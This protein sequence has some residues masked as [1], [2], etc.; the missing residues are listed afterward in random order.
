MPP[1]LS[2]ARGSVSAL[3]QVIPSGVPRRMIE[4]LLS[5]LAHCRLAGGYIRAVPGESAVA[6]ILF[7]QPHLTHTHTPSLRWHSQD[8]PVKHASS[9]TPSLHPCTTLTTELLWENTLSYVTQTQ[10]GVSE[11]ME[12]TESYDIC[13]LPAV[14]PE[15][16]WVAPQTIICKLRLE[17]SRISLSLEIIWKIMWPSLDSRTIWH[18]EILLD[19]CL[20]CLADRTQKKGPLQVLAISWF[21]FSFSLVNFWKYENEMKSW[22]VSYTSM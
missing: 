21:F 16:H 18:H 15:L 17:A 5:V 6:G 4:W 14:G 11:S 22:V 2:A 20:H 1:K 7:T 8:A 9:L 19:Y 10:P 13:T 12:R 3:S